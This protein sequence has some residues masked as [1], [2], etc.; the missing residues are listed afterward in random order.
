MLSLQGIVI[1]RFLIRI[2]H[3][4]KNSKH[5]IHKINGI[6][7]PEIP[8]TEL[9]N[10]IFRDIRKKRLTNHLRILDNDYCCYDTGSKLTFNCELNN[11]FL[12]CRNVYTAMMHREDNQ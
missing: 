6:T 10:A 2:L 7:T 11:I 12:S 4:I 3:I 1:I 9:I 8:Q 5:I